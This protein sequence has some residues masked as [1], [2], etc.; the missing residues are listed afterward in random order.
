PRR[1][2]RPVLLEQRSFPWVAVAAA[3]VLAVGI[4]GA[5][6]RSGL[7]T[8]PSASTKTQEPRVY[9][10]Q[11][12]QR[13]TLDLPDGT[14]L[15]L[16]YA[17]TIRIPADY[18]DSLRDVYLEG[19]AYF[20]V[21]HDST[22][23]FRVH[24]GNTVA[25]DLGTK[26]SVRAYPTDRHVEVA[27]SEGRVALADRARA[28]SRAGT[29]RAAAP[30]ATKSDTGTVPRVPGPDYELG[31]GDVVTVD[32]E[33]NAQIRRGADMRIYLAWTQDRT[34]FDNTPLREVA[35]ELSRRYNVDVSVSDSSI[36]RLPITGNFST[37]PVEDVARAVALSLDVQL[38]RTPTG[39]YVFVPY[40]SSHRRE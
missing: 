36:A 18:G 13:A 29:G 1:P 24:A 9:S 12:G 5:M 25:R 35:A 19:E 4:G 22:R 34:Y 2:P 40:P 14:R 32:R 15:F 38:K 8:S 21:A 3:T 28:R 10:T 26:F 39:G 37:E 7:L 11:R 20:D 31:A 33:G 30:G 17:S 16:G 23:P 6:W 27:V